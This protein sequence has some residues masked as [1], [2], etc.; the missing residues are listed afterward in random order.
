MFTHI[1]YYYFRL[2]A[3]F[4]GKLGSVGSPLGPPPPTVPEENLWELVEWS[5]YRPDV[6]RATQ[7]PAS[8]TE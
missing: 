1:N 4:P 8:K 3:I 7:P 2:T 6:F 5:F